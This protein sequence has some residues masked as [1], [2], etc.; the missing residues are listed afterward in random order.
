M[1]HYGLQRHCQKALSLSWHYQ[2]WSIRICKWYCSGQCSTSSG[3]WETAVL[4][5][6]P[7]IPEDMTENKIFI[8]VGHVYSAKSSKQ[9]LHCGLQH[10][11]QKALS[12]SLLTLPTLEH[13]N[14]QMIHVCSEQCS[15]SWRRWERVLYVCAAQ[16]PNNPRGHDAKIKYSSALDTST[17]QSV[18]NKIFVD[19]M[20]HLCNRGRENLRVMKDSF[21]CW[22]RFCRGTCTLFRIWKQNKKHCSVTVMKWA[23]V[24]ECMRLSRWVL[25]SWVIHCICISSEP[26]MW[27]I[28]A[29]QRP[30]FAKLSDTSSHKPQDRHHTF[31]EHLHI[32]IASEK[33]LKVFGFMRGVWMTW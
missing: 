4:H 12:L 1:L 21:C 15:T 28:L 23:K 9:K 25:S 2:R 3:R 5:K 17:P 18:Q 14:L 7:I 10:H 13:S 29:V 26:Q 8:C 22:P 6:D 20:L 32:F 19:M 24:E 33:V 31:G 16:G 30:K 27:G 11:C